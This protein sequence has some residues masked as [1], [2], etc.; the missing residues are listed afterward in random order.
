MMEEQH[1]PLWRAIEDMFGFTE[2]RGGYTHK[3]EIQE[4]LINEQI[5]RESQRQM[6][7]VQ[8]LAE[9]TRTINELLQCKSGVKRRK[10]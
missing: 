6:E 5:K 8:Q 1:I 7:L 2:E 9:S 3:L 10:I 4:L